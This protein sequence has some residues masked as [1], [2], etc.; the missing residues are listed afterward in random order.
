MK[1]AATIG[2]TQRLRKAPRASV[3]LLSRVPLFEGLSNRELRKV[4]SLAEEVWMN[5]GKVVI[6]EGEP[7]DAFFVLL[8]GAA[9][10]TRRGTDRTLKRLGPGDHFGELALLD[11]GPR[12]ATVVAESSL[13]V[14]RIGR[15]AFRRLLLSEP[16]VGLKIAGQLASWI[17]EDQR[18][19]LA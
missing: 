14:I 2:S 4:A 18:R 17:R 15:A 8:D 9:K 13:D 3:G 19:L 6:E 16:A 7:G 10:V 5:P 12:T 11:G 1:G